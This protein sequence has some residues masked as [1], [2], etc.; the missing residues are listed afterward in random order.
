ML[1]TTISSGRVYACD[2]EGLRVEGDQSIC[3]FL[4]S[5]KGP[6]LSVFAAGASSRTLRKRLLNDCK[7]V[8]DSKR[9]YSAAETHSS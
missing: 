8:S 1:I 7:S 5:S 3:R 4:M 6:G 2:I 9:V